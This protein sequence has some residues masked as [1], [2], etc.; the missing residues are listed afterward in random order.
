MGYKCPHCGEFFGEDKVA[1]NRHMD[2]NK[3]CA[4]IAGCKLLSVLLPSD[5]WPK[6]PFTNVKVSLN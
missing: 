3:A 6:L 2:E 4:A 5:L 1:F